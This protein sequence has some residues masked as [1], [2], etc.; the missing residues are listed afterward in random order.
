M[1][2]DRVK[3]LQHIDR[4]IGFESDD[5]IADR[6]SRERVKSVRET[7]HYYY[8]TI[9]APYAGLA[10]VTWD[11][12]VTRIVACILALA[13]AF[14]FR[15]WMLPV[16]EG[17]TED[18]N[19]NAARL[20]GFMVVLLSC[21]QAAFYLTLAF[22]LD[23]MA[24]GTPSWLPILALGL[25]AA[26]TQGAALTGIIFAS[27]VIFFCFVM[28]VVAAVLYL[29]A[30]SNIPASVAT[31]VLTAV[32]FYIAETSH[33]TQ[34]RLFQAQYDADAALL[35]MERTNT[36]LADARRNAQY[37]AETDNLT[38]LRSRLAFIHDIEA[39][40]DGGQCGLL[41]VIDLDRFKPINDLYGHHAGDIVLRQVALRLQRVLPQGT[42]V[43]R[44]GGDEFGVFIA[45]SSCLAE[46][47]ELVDVC[48][49]ALRQLCK[50]MR[51]ANAQ[52]SIGACAG[53]RLLGEDAPDVDQA[54][55]DADAALY[56][57][58]RNDMIET[59]LFD[60]E[61]RDKNKRLHAIETA[62]LEEGALDQ[63]SL[64]YQPI[65]NLRT[66]QLSSFEALA[67]W[68]HPV[69]G[70]ISPGQ[71]IPIAE[72]IGCIRPITLALLSRAVDF[73]AEWPAS[74]RLSFNLSAAHICGGDAASEIVA[75]IKQKNYPAERLQLEITETAMLVDF[76]TARRNVDMLREAGCRV[77]LDDF[78]AGFASLVYLREIR[79]D[80]VKID[81]SLIKRA[82]HPQ[83]RDMLRGVVKMIAAMKL[84][85]VAEFIATS[86]DRETARE[87]GAEFG[88][89][90][91][92]GYPLDEEGT[93]DLLAQ[94]HWP[95][96]TKVRS[97]AN[98]ELDRQDALAPSARPLPLTR[99]K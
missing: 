23:G 88:Q 24:G 36:E 45:G 2:E 33:R 3:L 17:K 89:G 8:L 32:N 15:H 48:D 40:L 31:V 25:L 58:K 21:T 92:L 97:L 28:P 42:V 66:G 67:R 74:C 47:G 61:I 34:L 98:W 46:L 4:L 14:R 68:E 44:L 84:E 82:R 57:A 6:F 95:H 73:A 86:G 39:K 19:R 91:H 93:R 69:L 18:V 72:R 76:A 63:L 78:G 50:P 16:P 60:A 80:K 55:R 87:L 41:A 37:Q 43:G 20:T 49:K 26:L 59:K 27:R 51:L 9:L 22:D 38:G 13:V 7:I 35:R 12:L 90:Y 29:F 83:G 64:A 81:G 99:E 79:F 10:W 85:S 5:E 52:V 53:A 77:A 11:H 56:F 71:F 65:F 96:S 75:L 62:L 54:L 94:Y 70:N 30:A 1:I